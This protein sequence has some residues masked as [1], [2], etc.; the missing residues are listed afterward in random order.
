[1]TIFTAT[2]AVQ[3][4]STY[5]AS[6]AQAALTALIAEFQYVFDQIQ[7]AS[8]GGNSSITLTFSK[9]KYNRVL[10]LL[11]SNG[12]TVSSL[13]SDG[14]ASTDL[15]MQ[16]PITIQ[17]GVSVVTPTYTPVTAIAPTAVTVQVNT[18]LNV[19][20]V[21]TGGTAPYTWAL[22][23]K[24][25]TGLSFDTTIGVLSG[26]PTVISNEYN[27]TTISVTDTNGQKFSQQI[28]VA[29]TPPLIPTT[30]IQLLPDPTATA[31][32]AQTKANIY[33]AIA[34]S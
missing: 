31:T 5:T 27:L 33:L 12:Y 9:Y 14:V 30:G 1:M 26:T 23:G 15:V 16:Y 6:Q 25:D 2:Q 20:F 10:S 8:T 4:L 34:L 21:P 17:W 19:K 28:S 7:A 18:A 13:P 24:L 29:V 32:L 22:T 3:A 11:T